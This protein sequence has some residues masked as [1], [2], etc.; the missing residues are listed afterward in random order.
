MPHLPNELLA[1]IIDLTCKADLLSLA[2]ANKSVYNV[3]ESALRR[4]T[5]LKRRYSAIKFGINFHEKKIIHEN[6]DTQCAMLFLCTIIKDPEIAH[7]PTRLHLALD[8]NC[9]EGLPT[10]ERSLIS[11]HSAQLRSLLNTYES[12]PNYHKEFE[13]GEEGIFDSEGAAMYLLLTLLP[14]LTAIT[15]HNEYHARLVYMMQNSKQVVAEA[16]RRLN[17][18]SQQRAL[19]RLQEFALDQSKEVGYGSLRPFTVYAALPSMRILRGV[20]IEEENLQSQSLDHP[21]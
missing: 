8:I 13:I 5:A 3:T 21:M 15:F 9:Y 12:F 17:S 4:H 20:H 14:N 2:L 10:N 16:S 6:D 18:P 1:H 11:K 19:T 7:Y